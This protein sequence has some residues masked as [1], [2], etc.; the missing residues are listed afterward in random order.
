MSKKTR[1]HCIKQEVSDV[2]LRMDF[3]VTAGSS[4]WNHQRVVAGIQRCNG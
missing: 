3:G 1:T 2:V 4:I